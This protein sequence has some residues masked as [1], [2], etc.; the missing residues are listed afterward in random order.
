MAGMEFGVTLWG[1]GWLR[2]V[3]PISAVPDSKLPSARRLARDIDE[4]LRIEP[5]RVAALIEAERVEIEV[6]T[7][8]DAE[9]E[10]IDRLVESSGVRASAGDLP[11]ALVGELRSA[12]IEVA[13]R[14]EELRA[15]CSCRSRTEKCRHVLAAIYAVVLLVDQQPTRAVT[16]RSPRSERVQAL[17]DPDWISLDEVEADRFFTL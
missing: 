10:V 3:E 5:G 2:V 16:L 7:W 1:R 8:T 12:G 17:I 9:R 14:P 4:D 15:N 13:C 11:D 6:P